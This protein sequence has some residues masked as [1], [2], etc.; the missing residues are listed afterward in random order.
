MATHQLSLVESAHN[1]FLVSSILSYELG[2]SNTPVVAEMALTVLQDVLALS[3]CDH[4]LQLATCGL[5]G[6]YYIN[7]YESLYYFDLTGCFKFMN[8]YG[9]LSQ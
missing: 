5:S 3:L 6:P 2:V 7:T 9:E 4:W 8:C 1:P